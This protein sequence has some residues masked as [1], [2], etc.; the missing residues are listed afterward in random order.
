MNTSPAA[1]E[2]AFGEEPAFEAFL[3]P[4]VHL[5]ARSDRVMVVFDEQGRGCEV[6]RT[7]PHGVHDLASSGMVNTTTQEILCLGGAGRWPLAALVALVD[8]A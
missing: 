3:R 8:G 2:P 5:L 1:Q 6:P 4:G 7:C